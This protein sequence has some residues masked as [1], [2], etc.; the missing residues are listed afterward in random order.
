[1]LARVFGAPSIY[2]ARISAAPEREAQRSQTTPGER[3]DGIEPTDE[4]NIEA[5]SDVVPDSL[6]HNLEP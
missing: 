5:P 1:V 4:L 2:S 3:D 6:A